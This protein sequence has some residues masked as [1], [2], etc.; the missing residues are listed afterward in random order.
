MPPYHTYSSLSPRPF[1]GHSS[2]F[3]HHVSG[4]TRGASL[5]PGRNTY[6]DALIH[7]LWEPVCVCVCVGPCLCV[8]LRVC[9]PVHVCIY[10]CV[11]V[12]A[13]VC[14][15]VLVY[16]CVYVCPCMCVYSIYTFAFVYECPCICV[17][18]FMCKSLC[19]YVVQPS[20]DLKHSLLSSSITFP[21]GSYHMVMESLQ[22][23]TVCP[24]LY[25]FQTQQRLSHPCTT[26]SLGSKTNLCSY[27]YS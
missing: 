24:V 1:N 18:M 13:C 25:F 9:M 8:C 15:S 10:V 16:V 17:C 5:P 19:V 6:N 23:S 11:Y 4:P 3:P 2:S 12:R 20:N 26:P 21:T 27:P 7:S 22:Q 14:V